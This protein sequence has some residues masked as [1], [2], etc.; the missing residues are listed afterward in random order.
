L[1]VVLRSGSS[2]NMPLSRISR[3][4]ST[5]VRC[6]TCA[7]RCAPAELPDRVIVD[8]RRS[9]ATRSRAR[10]HWSI[11]VPIVARGASV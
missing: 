9:S 7:A 3:S 4:I 1:T 11:I 6:A 8:G 5:D 2:W 10:T